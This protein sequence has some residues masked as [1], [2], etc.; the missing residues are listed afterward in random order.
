LQDSGYAVVSIKFN[1][2]DNLIQKNYFRDRNQAYEIVCTLVRAD[3]KTMRRLIRKVL[4]KNDFVFKLSK[5]LYDFLIGNFY[6]KFDLL[7]TYVTY[8]KI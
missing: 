4:S 6:W 3:V 7:D 1:A 8:K 2:L 5:S